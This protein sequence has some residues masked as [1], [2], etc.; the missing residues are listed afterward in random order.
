MAKIFVYRYKHRILILFEYPMRKNT[1]P[2]E[3][4]HMRILL[5]QSKNSDES[6]SKILNRTRFFSS[7]CHTFSMKKRKKSS[8]IKSLFLMFL[9]SCGFSVHVPKQAHAQIKVETVCSGDACD[10][11]DVRYVVVSTA[12]NLGTEPVGRG[13]FFINKSA[14]KVKLV[15]KWVMALDRYIGIHKVPYYTC[16]SRKHIL[17]E[18]LVLDSYAKKYKKRD[19][20]I[21]CMEITAHKIVNKAP[22]TSPKPIFIHS[23][24]KS[25]VV[26]SWNQGEQIVVLA[27]QYVRGE[28]VALASP[29]DGS[30]AIYGADVL[31][32]A[33]P[34]HNRHNKA[35]FD[36]DVSKGKSGRYRLKVEY[37]AAGSR[38]VRLILDGR[39]IAGS[40]LW[41]TTGCWNP[42][43]QRLLPQTEVNLTHGSHTLIL[44]RNGVFPHIRK[45]VF[46]RVK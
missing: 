39:I 7:S 45:I 41:A 15:V 11:M 28:N 8:Q 19:D 37:A 17:R 18:S 2:K 46:E 32:N 21:F 38:P 30:A 40:A 25:N 16:Q 31:L 1:L 3:I 26:F 22:S 9:V 14:S 35:E 12:K 42:S 29:S 10:D 33:P 6:P 20:A 23:S 44:E 27:T 43:C 36:F 5:D 13:W 4:K 34:Y 24:K